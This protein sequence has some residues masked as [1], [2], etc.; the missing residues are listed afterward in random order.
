MVA[1]ELGIRM[2]MMMMLL[3]LLSRDYHH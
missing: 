2:M 3:S 1:E